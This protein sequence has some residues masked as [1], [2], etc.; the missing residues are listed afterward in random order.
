VLTLLQEAA[1]AIDNH[2]ADVSD[3]NKGLWRFWNRKAREMADK[4]AVV[5]VGNGAL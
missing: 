1:A 4:S 3:E 2:A 5:A